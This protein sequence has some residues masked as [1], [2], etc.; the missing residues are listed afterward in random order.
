MEYRLQP[1]RTSGPFDKKLALSLPG[2]GAYLVLLRG[3]ATKAHSLA[4]VG[5]LDLEVAEIQDEGR[6]RVAVR[7]CFRPGVTR[8]LA[9]LAKSMLVGSFASLSA[10]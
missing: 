8:V 5:S 2:K 3:G 7:D 9:S 6:V 1:T 10:W 4:L